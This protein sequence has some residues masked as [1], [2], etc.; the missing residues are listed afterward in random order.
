MRTLQSTITTAAARRIHFQ[1]FSLSLRSRIVNNSQR[2]C[3]LLSTSSSSLPRVISRRSWEAARL[4]H[5]QLFLKT[6][7]TK[8]KTTEETPWPPSMLRTMYGIASVLIPYYTV[9]FI[10]ANPHCR[11]W[12]IPEDEA[13]ETM[14]TYYLRRHFGHVDV[15]SISYMDRLET[16]GNP[17]GTSTTSTT[18]KDANDEPLQQQQPDYR[19]PNELPRSVRRNEVRLTK[20]QTENPL[21]AVQVLVYQDDNPNL[22]Q[23]QCLRQVPSNVLATPEAVQEYM[24]RSST[25]ETAIKDA[26]SWMAFQF[27]V[28]P[29]IV[30]MEEEEKVM[31]GLD[32]GKSK[33]DPMLH[34][35]HS[36]SPWHYINPEQINASNNST[37]NTISQDELDRQRLRY[38]IQELQQQIK[39]GTRSIDDVEAEIKSKKQELKRLQRGWFW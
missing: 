38:E 26:N 28:A 32:D 33:N 22:Y 39:S 3:Q 8:K 19:L 10:V 21:Q 1:Q 23:E 24:G 37:N 16:E 25:S 31:D 7:S 14:W 13:K 36:L 17:R 18:T 2:R 29:R 11:H 27:P 30:E 6:N 12:L 5:P 35:I 4:K 20:E 15:D 9:W 34:H